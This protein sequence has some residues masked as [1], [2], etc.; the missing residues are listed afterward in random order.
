MS[1]QDAFFVQTF[2]SGTAALK[3]RVARELQERYGPAM[4]ACPEIQE[5]LAQLHDRAR[6]LE[7]HMQSMQL[8]RLCRSCATQTGGGC[9]SASMADNTDSIML[10]TNLLLGIEVHRQPHHGENCCYLGAQGCL[11]AIKPFFCLTYNCTHILTS[12]DSLSLAGLYQ[13]AGAVMGQQ[14]R[15]EALLLAAISHGRREQGSS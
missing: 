11:F 7:A 3:L 6:A 12:A 13:Q 15:L 2:Y 9:C 4:T 14:G 5:G 10:L 1:S 8:G